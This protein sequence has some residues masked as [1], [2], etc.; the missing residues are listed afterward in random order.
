MRLPATNTTLPTRFKSRQQ[1]EPRERKPQQT[2]GF[3]IDLAAWRRQQSLRA[4]EQVIIDHLIEV[5][6]DKSLDLARPLGDTPQTRRD[7]LQ[8]IDNIQQRR[9]QIFRRLN[10]GNNG[11]WES[12]IRKALKL[13]AS[14]QRHVHVGLALLTGYRYIARYADNSGFYYELLPKGKDALQQ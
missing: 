9:W 4:S 6:E 1:V 11:V 12:D 14:Q 13:P 5:T 10:P 8:A 2:G 7:L 3:R